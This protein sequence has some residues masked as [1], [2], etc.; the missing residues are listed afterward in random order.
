[1]ATIFTA[2]FDD[3]LSARKFQLVTLRT[4]G[5]V[6]ART[7]THGM[8]IGDNGNHDMI[9]NIPQRPAVFTHG[10]AVR[11]TDVTGQL[12]EFWRYRDRFLNQHVF[13]RYYNVDERIAVFHADSLTEL[14]STPVGS[15]R[16]QNWH[17][18]ELQVT[19]AAGGAGSVAMQLD[20]IAAGA[21]AGVTT[22][23]T[24]GG[25]LP[26]LARVTATGS[27]SAIEDMY[28][29][30]WYITDDS[31][32]APHNGFLGDVAIYNLLPDGNGTY[33]EQ[34]GSD[35][36][37][38]DNYLLVDEF[39]NPDDDATYVE[40]ATN[41]ARDIYTLDNLPAGFSTK[42]ILGVNLH[43]YSR[44]LDGTPKQVRGLIRTGGA[45]FAGADHQLNN[46]SYEIHTDRW[47][48]NPN[49]VSAWTPAEI[50]ALEAGQEVRP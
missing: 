11:F 36:N 6:F 27:G 28:S 12:E 23:S 18:I 30:D 29:D 24:V 31:G 34:V 17:Y 42:D 49:T 47:D 48:I 43:N 22:Q 38:I 33:S 19:I 50:D 32:P 45:D 15:V 35:G 13:L 8:R 25:S 2:S 5:P 20:G 44:K 14:A 40:S 37:Q 21:A 9:L 3:G 39:P 4:P 1:M 41:G 10:S 16:F 7:G 46:A 26:E